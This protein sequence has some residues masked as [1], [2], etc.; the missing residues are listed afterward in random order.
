MHDAGAGQILKRLA[1]DV[2]MALVFVSLLGIALWVFWVYFFRGPVDIETRG[3][4]SRTLR[5]EPAQPSQVE[6]YTL[7]HFHS[8]N[9]VVLE[10][11]KSESLCVKCHG[12][13]AHSKEKKVRSFFNAHSWFIACEVC[14]LKAGDKD[15]VVFRCLTYDTGEELTELKGQAGSYGAMIVPIRLEEGIVKRFDESDDKEFIEEFIRLEE[16]LADYQKE[17]S[18]ERIHKI[19]SENPV[20]CDECHTS[21]GLLNFE[22]LLYS[23]NTAKYLESLDMGAMTKTYEQFHLPAIL[24][25][26]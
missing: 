22:E 17:L 21:N 10:G 18:Q 5:D 25:P 20:N 1:V 16:H 24:N 13:Y 11:I 15:D 3:F 23:P 26:K 4:V 12:D 14:H 19:L 2:L 9:E 7:R 8:L 6:R